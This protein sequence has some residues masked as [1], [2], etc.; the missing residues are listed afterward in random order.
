MTAT[1]RPSLDQIRQAAT[2]FAKKADIP[3]LTYPSA[4]QAASPSAPADTS[5]TNVTPIRKRVR[6]QE[7][8]PIKRVS[9][10][11][12]A[13][14]IKQISKK[15]WEEGCTKRFIFLQAFRAIGFNINDIDFQEDGRR[16]ESHNA[17]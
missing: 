13:Y 5:A 7:P 14:L 2:D 15:A 9:L 12:P 1:P 10:D 16:D 4:N 3:T 11:L 6:K 8:T 17:A